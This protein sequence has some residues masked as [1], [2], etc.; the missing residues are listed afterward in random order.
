MTSSLHIGA[1]KP[2]VDSVYEMD[3]VLQAYEKIMTSRAK[4]KVIV[5]VDPSVD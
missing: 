4:G 2:V 5:K 3:H 1:I